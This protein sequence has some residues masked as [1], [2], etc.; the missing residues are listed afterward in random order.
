M[1]M[2]NRLSKWSR[3]SQKMVCLL[4]A[5]GLMYACK[6]EYLLDDEKPSFLNSSIYESL[7]AQGNFNTY[8]RLLSDEQVNTGDR[9]LK[10]VLERTGSKTLFVADD[11]AWN[12]FFAK[13]ATLPESNPWHYATCYENL[14]E[15]Q[16]KLLIHTSMLNNAIVLENLASNEASGSSVPTRGEYMRRYTDV[17][18]IDTITYLSPAEIP[19]NF[20]PV[21]KDYWERF[22]AE[23]GGKGLYLVTD[24]SVSMML[25][26]TAEHMT[27]NN[28]TDDDFRIF[29]GQERVTSDV[30][31]YDA[32]IDSL[33]IVCENGYIN[34]TSKPLCPLS[35]MAEVI[36]VNGKTN[37]FSHMLDRYSAPF[38]SRRITEAYQDLHPEFKDSIFIKRYFSELSNG[39]RALNAEPGPNGTYR[40]YMPYKDDTTKDKVPSLKFDPA[41]NG[42]HDSDVNVQKDMA[43]MFV[44]CD[45]ALWD[46]F[47][48]GGGWNLIR[49]YYLKQ[50]TADEIPYVEPTTLEELYK[51]IDCIPLGTLDALINIIMMRSFVGSVPSKMTKLRDDAQEQLFNPDDVEMID[52][53]LL[54]SNGAVYV[55]KEIYGPADYTSVT[56]PAYISTTNNIMKWA[57][58][59]GSRAEETDYMG[60]NYYAYLKA[61]QS[62]FTV[63][64]PSDAA[65][66]YY[67][68]P[69]SMKSKTP[70]VISMTYTNQ[71]FPII[72]KCYKYTGPYNS[73]GNLAS[74]GE[75]GAQLQ[76]NNAKIENKDVTNRLKD[77]LESHTIVHDGT[78]PMILRNADGT[79]DP[80]NSTY[81]FNE[82]YLSKNGNAIKVLRDENNMPLE[83]KGGF[84]LENE[85]NGITDWQPGVLGCNV[86]ERNDFLKNGQTYILDAPLVPTYRS[87]WSIMTNDYKEY[88]AE[89]K[90]KEMTESDW[91]NY[92]YRAFYE[93]CMCDNE[94]NDDDPNWVTGFDNLVE[95]CGLVSRKLTDT[96]RF[97]AK[98]KYRIF[99][100]AN[101]K[102]SDK[103]G[104]SDYNV[105]FFN[106]YHYT[107]FV[108]TNEAIKEEI[109]LR[110]L[111]TWASIEEDYNAHRKQE[112][113][114]IVDESGNPILD[115]DGNEQYEPVFDEDGKPVY[116]TELD[117]QEDSLRI[118][119]KIT[120]L[121]N[122][123]R[124]HFADDTEFVD[125][126]AEED[127]E[128]VTSSYDKELG[129]FCKIHVDRVE[130]GAG[131]T[132]RVSDDNRWKTNANDKIEVKADDPMFTN[133]LARDLTCSNKPRDVAMTNITLDASST[134]VL[135]LIPGVLNHAA[136]GT[137]GKHTIIW[138]SP[139]SCRK[140]LKRYGL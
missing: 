89:F 66:Q 134:A 57:I 43:A 139:S 34:K 39:G 131:A 130:N 59:N 56:S 51:Q 119:A 48:G 88:K 30:H 7:Q 38:Y 104:G 11:A 85:R 31:I 13:N 46:Y 67:Y 120:Y 3:H 6:D 129:L 27:K 122:F 49:T 103:S 138:S 108:P 90:P 127:H 10:E 25:H 98:K 70:R 5:C 81:V 22:R 112:T 92:P 20:S 111:P 114:V 123:I 41:W 106:N 93:L 105:Q 126:R 64:M 94:G 97:S 1:R 117:T 42:Y 33:D 2:T 140:Y 44:P 118:Q 101:Q 110:G 77:I 28:I 23:K 21:D 115:G 17:E 40:P 125:K 68:D 73:E 15:A 72:P 95:G 16:K 4:A 58:Y 132:L 35:S 74:I 102:T 78:N 9:S 24:S 32:K 87:V 19:A 82:Y 107:I 54:A 124:N 100:N 60:L 55:M 63:M 69:T 14:S 71:K 99:F 8:L 135:H 61:M 79:L 133:V 96:E 80:N 75:M 84:Q 109:D 45:K 50:G 26:F 12:A 83:I 136:L 86:T 128:M 116:L 29:M 37:I 62:M 65:M 18:T 52:T 76:G 137:D 53:C 36:R 121:T 91:E 113:R 47:K